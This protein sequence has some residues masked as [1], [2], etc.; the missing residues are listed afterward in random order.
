MSEAGADEMRPAPELMALG[1]RAIEA[2]ACHDARR[3]E[4]AAGT[5]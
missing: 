5:R 4:V 1:R 3:F 2:R